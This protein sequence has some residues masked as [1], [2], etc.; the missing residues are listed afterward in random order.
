[1]CDFRCKMKSETVKRP[2]VGWKITMK[3]HTGVRKEFA[4]PRKE[5]WMTSMCP[6]QRNAS[7]WYI[8]T[9][10]P[11]YSKQ[12]LLFPLF[13][14]IWKVHYKGKCV[15][16]TGLLRTSGVRAEYVKFIEKVK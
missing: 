3:G 4:R 6:T 14:E 11:N 12:P 16:G 2:R 8:Y 15:Y 5:G 10:K 13:Y 7:G 9:K 1:M